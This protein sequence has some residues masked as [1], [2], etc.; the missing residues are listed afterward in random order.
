M[1][2]AYKP[3]GVI[4]KILAGGGVILQGRG[5]GGIH[6]KCLMHFLAQSVVSPGLLEGKNRRVQE[7]LI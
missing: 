3:R 4:Q 6:E 2:G 5:G 1:P 7:Y